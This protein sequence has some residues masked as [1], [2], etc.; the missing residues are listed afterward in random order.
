M[1][2]YT[3]LLVETCHRRGAHA[4]GGMAAF[5]PNRARRRGQRDRDRQACARTRSARPA[6]AST[7]PGS[8]TPTSCRSRPRSST[9]CLGER[10]NQ[11]DRQREDVAVERRRTCSTSRSPAARSP[12]PA[13]ARTSPWR[14]QYLD[15]WLR[16]TA[17]RR[18]TT[19]WRTPRPPRDARSQLWQW[20]RHGVREPEDAAPITEARVRSNKPGL[21]SISWRENNPYGDRLPVAESL[22]QDV[23][24]GESFVEFL[25]LPAYELIN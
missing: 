20:V 21:W 18:S 6:T 14:I 15:S 4:I 3:E 12:R 17:R 8:R 22:R 9:A 2:A 13:S 25:T 16:G 5:I 23:A 19:S 10:P 24:L 11:K 7:A 1:R